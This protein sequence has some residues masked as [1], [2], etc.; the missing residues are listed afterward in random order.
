MIASSGPRLRRNIGITVFALL[1][2]VACILIAFVYTKA[3]P[4]GMSDAELRAAGTWLFDRPRDIGSFE[5][6]GDTG[7]AFSPADLDGQWTLLFFGFTYC[8]DICPTTMATLASFYRALDPEV[9]ADT[10]IVMVSV[11]PARDTPGKLADYVH[12]FHPEFQGVTGEF[13]ALQRFALALSMPFIKAPGSAKNYL[14][15]H[16]ANVAILN[17]RGHYVG[18]F[19]GP[20]EAESLLAMYRAVRA[21]Y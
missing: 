7:A 1:A 16:S 14:V 19:R 9:A 20:V 12:Y 18:F 13:M 17:D 6:V 4:E 2:F 15:E 3:R 10:D 5:L 21:R 8:P 11:D